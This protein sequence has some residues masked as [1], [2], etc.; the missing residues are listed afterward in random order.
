MTMNPKALAVGC[1]L[2]CLAAVGIAA[3]TITPVAYGAGEAT[4]GVTI[5]GIISSLT[6]LLSGGGGLWTLLKKLG[7]SALD[8]A[9]DAVKEIIKDYQQG[10]PLEVAEDAAL[11][12][13]L[14][15]RAKAKDVTGSELA[16][17]LSQHIW[18]EEAAVRK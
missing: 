1:F 7:G 17:K 14:M 13:V 2:V 5:T 9:V 12:T 15:C 16:T 10:K 3:G 18:Q 4:T 6:A 8:P 11:L